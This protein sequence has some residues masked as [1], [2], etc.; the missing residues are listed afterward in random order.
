MCVGVG[1]LGRRIAKFNVKC[2]QMYLHVRLPT[3]LHG[4]EMNKTVIYLKK[5]LTVKR[6][7]G[8]IG[9]KKVKK[10]RERKERG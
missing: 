3:F 5:Y 4:M 1:G 6:L 9:E 7:T 10:G 2:V 8:K